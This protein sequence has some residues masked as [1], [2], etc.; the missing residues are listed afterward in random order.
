MEDVRKIRYDIRDQD[1]NLFIGNMNETSLR[2]NM[3]NGTGLVRT[4]KKIFKLK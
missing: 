1:L 2:L 3:D 4:L